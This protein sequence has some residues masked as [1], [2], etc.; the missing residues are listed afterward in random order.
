[1]KNVTE[2]KRGHLYASVRTKKHEG[3]ISFFFLMWLLCV[4]VGR[5]KEKGRNAAQLSP[6][7]H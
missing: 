4:H 7:P 2:P 3:E 1:M 6:V 5:E